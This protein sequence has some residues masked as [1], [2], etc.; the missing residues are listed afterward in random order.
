MSP[1]WVLVIMLG[2][3][4]LIVGG[5]YTLVHQAEN[6]S[7]RNEKAALAEVRA[8]ADGYRAELISLARRG[9]LTKPQLTAIAA[10][11][12]VDVRSQ[13]MRGRRLTVTFRSL[14][15]YRS[16]PDPYEETAERCYRI[17]LNADEADRS[18]MHEVGCV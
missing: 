13:E 8:Q 15:L 16:P 5:C 14:A 17:V 6:T 18:D 9:H 1:H 11:H 3:A 12:S 7:R 2:L 4:G 10:H